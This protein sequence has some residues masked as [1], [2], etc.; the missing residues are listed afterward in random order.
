MR[1]LPEMTVPFSTGFAG[2]SDV[3]R[4]AFFPQCAQPVRYGLPAGVRIVVCIQD[5]AQSGSPRG[6]GFAPDGFQELVI[7]GF[8]FDAKVTRYTVAVAKLQDYVFVVLSF[9][10]KQTR[11]G[12]GVLHGFT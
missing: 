5:D 1:S 10:K 11:P 6:P 4:K 7:V 3:L 8:L 2:R 9:D 12:V